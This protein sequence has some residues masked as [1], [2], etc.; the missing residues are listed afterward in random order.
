MSS[1]DNM[2]SRLPEGVSR[3]SGSF[4]TDNLRAVGAELDA[5]REEVLEFMPYRFFPTLAS[6]EDL[7]LS[8]ENFGVVR[9]EATRAVVDLTVSGTEGS[10]VVTGMRCVAD[11]IYFEVTA[12]AEIGESG[13]VSVPARALEAGISGNVAAG[14]ISKWVTVYVG[15]TGVCNEQ[16]A[17]GG[18]DAESDEDLLV[19]IK[20]RWQAPS[21]GGNAAD[22]IRWALAVDGVSRARAWSPAA[23]QVAVYIVAAG[24]V[25][26]N[27]ALLS[28]VQTAID[29]VKP[30][31]AAALVASGEAVAINVSASVRVMDG[32]A[33]ADV[34]ARCSEAVE[35]Y[36]T[37]ISFAGDV[38]SYAKIL[39]ALFV[40]GVAD[41]VSCTLNGAMDSVTLT[42]TQFPQKGVID[43]DTGSVT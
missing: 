22:Y 1:Y 25:A 21:T 37:K 19:R 29:A 39:N 16:A 36:L 4:A 31:G 40:E 7:T 6:G 41:V 18:S 42:R 12:D 5:L 27:S 11:G 9:R 35:E 28:A 13:S 33:A 20:Q 3:E 30:L 2:V 8:A 32:Y 34:T 15:I 23:G 38:V 24:N 17:V 10:R 26:A 14:A 43:I